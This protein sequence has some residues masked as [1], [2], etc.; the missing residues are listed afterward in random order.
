MKVGDLVK[1]KPN[2]PMMWDPNYGIVVKIINE[3]LVGVLWIGCE[4]IYQ[5]P[6]DKLEVMNEKTTKEY[7]KGIPDKK[8][9]CV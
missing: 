9:I 4:H 3:C 2:L 5:E 1:W 8:Q 6:I 7:K